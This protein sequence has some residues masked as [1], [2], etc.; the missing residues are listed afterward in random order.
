MTG[1]GTRG[2]WGYQPQPSIKN[3]ELWLEWQAHQL[4]TPDWWEELTTIPGSGRYKEVGPWKICA[5]FNIPAV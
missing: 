5:S 1:Q 2:R 4:D 3:Y